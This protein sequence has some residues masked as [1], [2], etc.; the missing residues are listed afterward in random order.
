[1]EIEVRE[2]KARSA[3]E[4]FLMAYGLLTY[5]DCQSSYKQHIH[6]WK[7]TCFEST[8]ILRCLKMISDRAKVLNI[9]KER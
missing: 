4:K 8:V 6:V 1:M 3:E 5:A 7:Y 9:E 2:S